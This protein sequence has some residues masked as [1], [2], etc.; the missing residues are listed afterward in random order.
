MWGEP[1]GGSK[2]GWSVDRKG[3]QSLAPLDAHTARYEEFAEATLKPMLLKVL[4]QRD[5]VYEEQGECAKLRHF[6]TDRLRAMDRPEGKGPLKTMVDVGRH[7]YVQAKVPDPTK[8]FVNVGLGV[9]VQY[10][11]PEAV[12][13]LAHREASL[14]DQAEA[15]TKRASSLKVQLKVV[16]E[17]VAEHAERM[18]YRDRD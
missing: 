18:G 7:F 4:E 15:L 3:M 12:E 2:H 14:D 6:I 8:I 16:G 10:T 5:K 9:H 1:E 13:H 11:L 17:A